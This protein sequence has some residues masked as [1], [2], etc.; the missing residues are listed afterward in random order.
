M[1]T[2]CTVIRALMEYLIVEQ[3]HHAL[4]G[5]FDGP[6]QMVYPP[7]VIGSED[8]SIKPD[9]NRFH[10]WNSANEC[11]RFPLISRHAKQ[12]ALTVGAALLLWLPEEG[13]RSR[14]GLIVFKL[15]FSSRDSKISEI[16]MMGC[17]TFTKSWKQRTFCFVTWATQLKLWSGLSYFCWFYANLPSMQ[18]SPKQEK[19]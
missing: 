1:F 12:M 16:K 9:Q 6:V 19:A 10:M 8:L 17:P 3:I 2:F 15:N 14:W 4:S 7:L 11:S 13:S 18:G 5:S